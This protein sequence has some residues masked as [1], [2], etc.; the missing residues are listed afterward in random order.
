MN[1]NNFSFMPRCSC[2]VQAQESNL[3]LKGTVADA[4]A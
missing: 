3:Q 4:V 2:G 1:N